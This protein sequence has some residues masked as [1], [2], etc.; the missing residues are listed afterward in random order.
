MKDTMKK[1]IIILLGPPGSGKGTQAA[2]LK[3]K[4]QLPHISTGDLL[5]THIKDKTTLGE[6]AKHYIE[7]GQLVPDHLIIDM[8]IKR[9]QLTDCQNGYILDGFPRTLDQAKVLM[10]ALKNALDRLVVINFEL[11]D[12]IIIERMSG[13][14]I[15]SNCSQ[16]YHIQLS[17]PKEAGICDLCHSPLI[18]RK[19]DHKEVVEKRLQVYHKETAPLINYYKTA[20]ILY[21]VNCNE[22]K[23]AVFEA[24]LRLIK[25]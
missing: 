3:E 10:I 12:S 16:P 11:S 24:T 9:I 6:A 8:L 22:P 25:S 7:A 23:E 2:L 20:K 19:D 1:N 15:C 5:R 18:Q 17:P 13:R 4:L 14:Q 21:S